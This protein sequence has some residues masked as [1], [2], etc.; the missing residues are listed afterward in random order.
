MAQNQQT[1][2]CLD[3][4][5]FDGRRRIQTIHQEISDFLHYQSHVWLYTSAALPSEIPGPDDDARRKIL[6]LIR[7][8]QRHLSTL[9][10]LIDTAEANNKDL[11]EAYEKPTRVQTNNG[12]TQN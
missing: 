10:W 5:A 9:C 7:A 12:W 11:I 6:A 1:T 2:T 4:P 3:V 8:E